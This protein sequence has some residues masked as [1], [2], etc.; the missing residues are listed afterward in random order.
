MRGTVKTW[1]AVGVLALA[2]VFGGVIAFTSATPWGRGYSG[3]MGAGHMGMGGPGMGMMGEGMM[4]P[5][6]MGRGPAPGMGPLQ[7]DGPGMGPGMM[8]QG[9]G[10]MMGMM[11]CPGTRARALPGPGMA[12]Q[13]QLSIDQAIEAVQRCLATLGDPDLILAEV[14]E[15]AYNFYAEVREW[16]TGIGAFEL[17][18]DK[19]TG[20]V[21]PEPGPNMMW[22]TKYGAMMGCP[23][24]GPGMGMMGTRAPAAEMPVTPEQAKAYAQRYLDIYLPGTMVDEEVDP[25]YGYYTIHVLQ[26]GRIYGMLSVNGYTGQVWYHWWHGPFLGMGELEEH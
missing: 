6:M 22:N 19:Y 14:M 15:F 24:M 18:V 8:G 3:M 4:G 20:A 13:A 25:F 2:L 11:L 17:L 16:S 12:P 1:T 23:M 26:G 10:Q 21:Y 5:G 7:Q 9:P